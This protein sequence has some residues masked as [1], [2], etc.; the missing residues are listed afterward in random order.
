[1]PVELQDKAFQNIMAVK[2]EDP[3]LTP[4]LMGD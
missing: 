3:D 1:V 2:A 4:A